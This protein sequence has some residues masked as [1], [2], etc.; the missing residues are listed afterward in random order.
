M[1]ESKQFKVVRIEDVPN[2]TAYLEFKNGLTTA[3]DGWVSQEVL[4]DAVCVKAF[5][6][7]DIDIEVVE[8]TI[9][10]MRWGFQYDY[11]SHSSAITQEQ[12]DLLQD[13]KI[14][15]SII[16]EKIKAKYPDGSIRE[17]SPIGLK[18]NKFRCD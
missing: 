12:M 15:K 9:S 1:I 3:P 10:C 4:K 2:A 18:N 7:D 14:S 6:K 17:L 5:A 8:F 13:P 16:I 11:T